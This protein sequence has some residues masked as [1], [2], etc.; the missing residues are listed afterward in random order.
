MYPRC[1]GSP[2]LPTSAAAPHFQKAANICPDPH[3]AQEAARSSPE[4]RVLQGS[5]PQCSRGAPTLGLSGLGDDS[6]ASSPTSL[7]PTWPTIRCHS[8][9]SGLAPEVAGGGCG[10]SWELGWGGNPH[11]LTVSLAQALCTSLNL[12]PHSLAAWSSR[13]L[14]PGAPWTQGPGR[15]RSQ[16]GKGQESGVRSAFP[17]VQTPRL[18]QLCCSPGVCSASVC[19]SVCACVCTHALCVHVHCGCECMC[20]HMC[21]V[22]HR[23]QE[24]TCNLRAPV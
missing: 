11:M 7:H 2:T 15:E 20:V 12:P 18:S 24:P 10:R 16:R 4:P 6:P 19:M 14:L 23:W 8:F 5:E 21:A 22:V 13:N 17:R 1:Q 9:P 3:R